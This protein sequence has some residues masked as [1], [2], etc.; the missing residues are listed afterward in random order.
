[1]ILNMV[2]EVT[3][4]ASKVAGFVIGGAAGL[5][6][7]STVEYVVKVAEFGLNILVRLL[8]V[9]DVTWKTFTREQAELATFVSIFQVLKEEAAGL[10]GDWAKLEIVMKECSSLILTLIDAEFG[11]KHI[12][13]GW[14]TNAIVQYGGAA[15]EGAFR[16]TSAFA[17]AQCQPATDEVHFV[18]ENIGDQRLVGTWT[19]DG[20]QNGKARYRKISDRP[21]TLMEWSSRH[22]TWSFWYKDRSFGRGWWFGWLG[23]GWREL[24]YSKTPSNEFPKSGWQH[25]EGALP[26]PQLVSAK[27]GGV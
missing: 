23:F 6:V 20:R 19:N 24:Y 1:V 16:V 4:A 8:D 14:V 2:K 10:L 25:D 9:I 5:A 12:N 18:V 13:L 3:L 17:Y 21:N 15:L 26:L 27:N 7:A 11:W 22:K